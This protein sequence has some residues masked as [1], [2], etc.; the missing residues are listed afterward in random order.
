MGTILILLTLLVFTATGISSVSGFEV[1]KAKNGMTCLV[2]A[3]G[4]FFVADCIQ[5]MTTA[6][7][8]P[9]DP[10]TFNSES[11]IPQSCSNCGTHCRDI[12][13]YIYKNCTTTENIKCDCKKG[14]FIA[15]KVKGDETTWYCKP[16][17]FC[18]PGSGVEKIG[19]FN[20]I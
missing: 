15:F 18:P 6:V 13:S 20:H 3:K 10:G 19:E 2:C 12:N 9:C 4:Y 14:Y 5:N 8:Q 11:G 17:S 1:Y 7:C 16:H